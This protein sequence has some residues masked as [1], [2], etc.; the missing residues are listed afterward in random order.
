M[1]R[2]MNRLTILAGAVMLLSCADTHR[3]SEKQVPAIVKSALLQ[4]YPSANRIKWEK[5]RAN[6]EVGFEINKT[7]YSLLIDISGNILETETDIK[8]GDLP[9]KERDFILRNFPGQKLKEAARIV[10]NKGIVTYEA[11][12]EGKDYIFDST[13]NVI[14]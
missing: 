11:E 6:Y 5:E 2:S 4:K 7:E 9:S 3:V 12:L 1:V 8:V 13:G 10:D 14:K